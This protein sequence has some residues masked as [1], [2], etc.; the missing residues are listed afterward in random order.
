M[1]SQRALNSATQS[2]LSGPKPRDPVLALD[3]DNTTVMQ[4]LYETAAC[5]ALI[6]QSHTPIAVDSLDGRSSLDVAL[7]VR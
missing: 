4:L 1:A 2:L 5:S 6:N 7:I 3:S